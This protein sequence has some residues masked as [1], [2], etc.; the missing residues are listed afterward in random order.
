MNGGHQWKV[1]V[2]ESRPLYHPASKMILHS[3]ATKREKVKGPK[4]LCFPTKLAPLCFL[5]PDHSV[6]FERTKRVTPGKAPSL[7]LA[8]NMSSNVCWTWYPDLDAAVHWKAVE[9]S[10]IHFLAFQ[11]GISCYDPINC[12]HS[13][14]AFNLEKNGE[15]LWSNP[16]KV[17]S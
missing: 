8:Y 13:N 1:Y 12:T 14:G 6:M 17:P 9:N 3:S 4:V 7:G 10:S 2:Q 5:I 11:G 15:D 16:F